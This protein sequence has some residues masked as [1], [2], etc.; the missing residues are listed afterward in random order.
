MEVL[1]KR[2]GVVSTT[3]PG[4]WTYQGC[5]TDPG[6]RTLADASYI[7]TTGMTEQSCISY[8]STLGYIYAG[9]EYS[10]EC[11]KSRTKLPFRPVINLYFSQQTAAMQL[12]PLELSLQ[13]PIVIWPVR[14]IAQRFAE[15]QAGCRFSGTERVRPLG[16]PQILA[17]WVMVSTDV[18][19][20]CYTISGACAWLH[21]R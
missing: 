15:G 14:E 13:A 7:N 11:C 10:Q 9:T 20:E 5:Y 19:R 21:I 4:T 12:P 16:Q 6:P 1:D 17:H 8:C 2:A 18:T 3:L